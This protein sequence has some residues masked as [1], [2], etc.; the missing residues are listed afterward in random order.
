MVSHLAAPRAKL[1]QVSERTFSRRTARYW[2]A[3]PPQS[4]S[5]GEIHRYPMLDST[6]FNSYCAMVAYNGTRG[7]A[8]NSVIGKGRSRGPP[9]SNSS[10]YP[11]SRW[12]MG[13]GPWNPCSAP[14]SLT[15]SSSDVTAIS[16]PRCR[17]HLTCD[18]RIEA[19]QELLALTR[20]LGQITTADQ[21]AA[22]TA[23]FV[24]WTSR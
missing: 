6:Y 18:P 4:T 5:N 22:F 9:C 23:E 3:R 12:S 13:H 20:S 24:F 2:Q 1:T 21:A 16:I 8:G 17:R 19:G 11:I 15:Q 7:W 10:C 14:C